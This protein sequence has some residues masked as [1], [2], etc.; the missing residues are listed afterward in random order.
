MSGFGRG[1]GRG[2]AGRGGMGRRGGTGAGPA[3]ECV[4]PRCGT[5]VPHQT[6]IPCTQVNCP[7]CGSPMIRGDSSAQP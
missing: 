4:C 5:R 6:G 3:G 1:G 7:Q 2:A